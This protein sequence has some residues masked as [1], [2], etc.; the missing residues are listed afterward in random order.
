MKGTVSACWYLTLAGGNLLVA[1]VALISSSNVRSDMK[2]EAGVI[3]RANNT[4]QL[5]LDF[6]LFAVGTTLI[7]GVFSGIAI[8]YHYI[9]LQIRQILRS[10]LQ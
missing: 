1:V 2:G 6:L 9:N 7:L 4:L 3:L 10:S 5:A 8:R